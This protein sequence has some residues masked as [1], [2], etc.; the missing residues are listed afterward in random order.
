MDLHFY[1]KSFGIPVYKFIWYYIIDILKL[2][3]LY[4]VIFMGSIDIL[5]WDASSRWWTS[6]FYPMGNSG[7]L[8]IRKTHPTVFIF[9]YKIKISRYAQN[10]PQLSFSI[11]FCL[12]LRCPCLSNLVIRV[13][14]DLLENCLDLNLRPIFRFAFLWLLSLESEH[15]LSSFLK[16]IIQNIFVRNVFIITRMKMNLTKYFEWFHGISREFTLGM[17]LKMKVSTDG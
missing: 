9:R 7:E 4:Y 3:L 1:W 16:K 8:K 17:F 12:V 5:K 13:E 14:I 10:W 11:T 2:T 15:P 6:L